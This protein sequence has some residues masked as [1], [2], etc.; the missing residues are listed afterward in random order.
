MHLPKVMCFTEPLPK[1]SEPVLSPWLLPL[2]TKKTSSVLTLQPLL[3]CGEVVLA[4]LI[5]WTTEKLIYHDY[6]HLQFPA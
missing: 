1:S 2:W 6:D 5:Y 3:P 4:F